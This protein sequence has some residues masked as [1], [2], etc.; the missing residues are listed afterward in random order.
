SAIVSIGM[1]P[2]SMQLASS[3][4][5]ITV[6][7]TLLKYGGD[8]AIGAYG[9]I[10]SLLTLAIQIVLGL[11]QGTQ[12]VVGFNFGAKLYD[13]MFRTLKTAIIIATFLTSAG[14]FTGLIF[15]RFSVGLFTSDKELIQIAAN[16]LKIVIFMFPVVG[17][18]IVISN[19]FQS[20][21]KAKISIFLSLTRQ[22]IFLV[23]AVLILPLAFGLNGAWAAFPVADGLAAI[24][25]AI[26]LYRFY[27]NFKQL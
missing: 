13:R 5:I 22:F 20:I 8:L 24:V 3:L 15:T 19:F 23:P 14:F 25:A 17:F 2:F 27:T 7:T 26:T 4:V 21:G 10:N 12:P 11:N 1:S 18:Q 9:I 16:A 6:N